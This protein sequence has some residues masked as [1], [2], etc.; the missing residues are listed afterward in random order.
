VIFSE[1]ESPNCKEVLAGL[2]GGVGIAELIRYLPGKSRLGK[3]LFYKAA[4]E[5]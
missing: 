1:R 2:E 3:L 4:E 5:F